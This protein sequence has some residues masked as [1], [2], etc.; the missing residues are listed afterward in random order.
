[1]ACYKTE[2]INVLDINQSVFSWA[3]RSYQCPQYIFAEK[4]DLGSI[5]EKILNTHRI[6]DA[7]E[8]VM[9]NSVFTA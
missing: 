7:V 1:M 9:Y 3:F 4:Y 6:K 2:W 5:K 8:Q